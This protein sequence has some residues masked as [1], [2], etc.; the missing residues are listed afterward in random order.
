M[1]CY[2]EASL[3]Q[4]AEARIPF[5]SHPN[6]TFKEKH[7][8]ELRKYCPHYY[9]EICRLPALFLVRQPPVAVPDYF[10][11]VRHFFSKTYNTL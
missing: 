9:P 11:K 10:M 6:P 3:E 1:N 7:L 2:P 5:C 4:L 8:E